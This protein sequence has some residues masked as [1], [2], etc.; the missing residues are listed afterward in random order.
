M[1]KVS[2]SGSPRAGVGKKDAA[3]LRNEGKIPCVLYG[4]TEQVSFSAN[5]NELKKIVWSPDVFMIELDINGRKGNA[6]IKDVQFHPVTDRLVHIDFLELFPGK[7][8]KVK[9]PVRLV[10]SAE[11]VKKG[12]KLLQNF[13]KISVFGAPENLPDLIEVNVEALNIGENIRIKHVSIDGIRLLE[14]PEAVIASVQ[15]TRNVAQ[16]A[17]AAA[18]GKK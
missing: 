18:T 5:E 3:D 11:G 8:V 13:R 7:P 12:G 17:A 14:A 15:T 16:E 4:G 6:L 1:K 10:G 2:L 9:L